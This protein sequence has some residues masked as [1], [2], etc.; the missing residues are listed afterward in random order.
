M[1]KHMVGSTV[2]L[3]YIIFTVSED[4]LL[5]STHVRG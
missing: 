5:L 2:V 3:G 1:S 4:L